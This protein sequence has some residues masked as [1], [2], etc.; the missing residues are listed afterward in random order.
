MSVDKIIEKLEM[1]KDFDIKESFLEDY[2]TEQEKYIETLKKI[3]EQ[4]LPAVDTIKLI[5]KERKN[6]KQLN[7]CCFDYKVIYEMLKSSGKNI[8]LSE[9]KKYLSYKLK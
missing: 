4:N 9:V 7:D 1:V 5:E 2:I 6:V 3:K 8:T